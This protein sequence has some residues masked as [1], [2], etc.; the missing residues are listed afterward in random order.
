M[1]EELLKKVIDSENYISGIYNYCDR[2]CEKCTYTDKC[3][4][5]HMSKHTYDGKNVV[6]DRKFWMDLENSFKL[7]KDMLNNYMLEH[8]IPFPD[9]K[10]NDLI[11]TEMKKVQ[12][13]V[14]ADPILLEAQNYTMFSSELLRDNNNF[15]STE[16]LLKP[17]GNE[18]SNIDALREAV[19]V[20]L[21]YKSLIFVKISRALHSYYMKDE[22]ELDGYEEDKLISAKIALLAVE[23]SMASWHYIF[24]NLKHSIDAIIDLLLLLNNIKIKIEKLI[25]D[26]IDY[27]RPYFD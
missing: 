18:L 17:E 14:K 19:E 5:Y 11:G 10:E 1:D 3:L 26:V 23:R 16:Y 27:K 22:H 8:N 7:V 24:E 9:E 12:N 6:T 25:P 13:L 15:T 4:S 21:Y 20:I 2:W